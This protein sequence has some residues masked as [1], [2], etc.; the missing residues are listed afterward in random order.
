MSRLLYSATVSVDGF[1]A[2]LERLG[3]TRGPV[4]TDIRLRV[5]R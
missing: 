4:A 3:M 1:T 2:A 5:V